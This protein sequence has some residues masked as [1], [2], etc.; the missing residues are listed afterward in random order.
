MPMNP[1]IKARWVK[2][3]RSRKYKQ[4]RDSLCSVAEDGSKTY[5][6]LGVLTDLVIQDGLEIKIEKS[7]FGSFLIYGHDFESSYL[8]AEVRD[9][10]G[11]DSSIPDV[12]FGDVRIDL[13]DL[14]DGDELAEKPR[15]PL[16]FRKIADL[17]EADASL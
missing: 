2:A 6:C 12:A 1:E 13:H 16:G 9:A 8:P 5:C 11:L 14:N 10:V 15:K 7:R 4:G 17:I 3:L